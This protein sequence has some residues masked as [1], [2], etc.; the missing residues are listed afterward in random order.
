MTLRV[1]LNVEGFEVVSETAVVSSHTI[2]ASTEE[3]LHYMP[4]AR[5]P[6]SLT[7]SE[8]NVVESHLGPERCY[9]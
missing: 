1:A 4:T 9:A 5:V 8:Q 6:N 7:R 3:V 2:M